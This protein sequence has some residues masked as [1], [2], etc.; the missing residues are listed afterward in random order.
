MVLIADSG[1]TKC[2]WALCEDNFHKIFKTKGLNPFFNTSQEIENEIKIHLLPKIK[3]ARI[4]KIFFYG[5]GCR[6]ERMF[7][8]KDALQNIFG[9]ANIETDSDLQGAALALFGNGKGIACILGTGSNSCLYDGGKVV[10]NVS[11][12][13]FILGDEGSGAVL[14]RRFLSDCLKNQLPEKIQKQFFAKYKISVAQII[15]NVY[16]QPN[17]NRYLA[18]FCPFLKANLAQS[19]IYNLVFDSFVDFFTRNVFQYTDYKQY[20]VSFCGSVA[21]HFADVLEVAALEMGLNF[22]KIIQSPIEE[23]VGIVTKLSSINEKT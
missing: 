22:G 4:D 8:V 5:A 7:V 23:L 3:N 19:A 17:P 6:P 12:L 20:T 13:G 1:S 18:Q 11:P 9:N 14:G 10:D 21:C 2:E 15:E 16:R